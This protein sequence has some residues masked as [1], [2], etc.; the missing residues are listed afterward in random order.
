[1][2]EEQALPVPQLNVMNAQPIDVQASII[3]D[4]DL[5]NIY[6]EIRLILEER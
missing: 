5:Q 3:T 2:S 1:M 4:N 6:H